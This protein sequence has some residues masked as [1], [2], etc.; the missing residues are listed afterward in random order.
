MLRSI[1]QSR[2]FTFLA[3]VIIGF[4]LLLI[5]KLKPSAESIRTVSVTWPLSTTRYGV[6]INPLS[7][8]KIGIDFTHDLGYSG[9][10]TYSRSLTEA[11]MQIEYS[12]AFLLVAGAIYCEWFCKRFLVMY[13]LASSSAAV[14]LRVTT[15]A[16]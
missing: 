15:T 9:I 7:F 6:W 1:L 12:L 3:V 4:F 11:M 16:F 13:L 5:I 14:G 10:G 2:W 8:M